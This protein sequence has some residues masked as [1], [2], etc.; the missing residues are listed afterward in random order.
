[1]EIFGRPLDSY[2]KNLR[3]LPSY[4]GYSFKCLRL[5]KQPWRILYHYFTLKP[6]AEPLVEL[7][8]G[9]KIFLSGDRYD[10]VTVFLIF[11]RQ[12]YG[13]IRPGSTVIDIGANVGVFSLY[14]AYRQARRVF[15]YEPNTQAFACLVRNVR[16]NHLEHIITPYP[17]AVAAVA[18]QTVKF[19]IQASPF[20]AIIDDD[21]HQEF[22]WVKTITL[23]RIVTD[24]ALDHVELLKMDCEG[25]EYDIVFQTPDR[26]WDATQSIR[27]EYHRA[28]VDR[29]RAFL[30]DRH[31]Q[32]VAWRSDSPQWGNLWLTKG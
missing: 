10:I 4:L 19:P 12:D 27:L 8:S 25:A 18:D 14:A 2:I 31:F 30:A 20:N 21:A 29:L 22:E 7:R 15:A 3:R 13:Q 9:L 26:V 32:V 16:E 6:M 23:E 28:Q 1:M 24:H 11:V 5:F 17:F